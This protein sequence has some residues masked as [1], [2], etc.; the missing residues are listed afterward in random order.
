[1]V[2]ITLP[3]RRGPE[4]PVRGA[5]PP[6]SL[7][8]RSGE[9]QFAKDITTFFA[10]IEKATA[11]NEIAMGM[12]QM[13]GLTESLDTFIA[14][15]PNA[16]TDEIK[17]EWDRI[18]TQI[19]DIPKDFSRLGKKK[20]KDLTNLN[21]PLARHQA[22]TQAAATKSKQEL[23]RAEAQR[24]LDIAN[25]DIPAIIANGEAGIEAGTY[26]RETKELIIKQDLKVV[27]KAQEKLALEQAKTTILGVAQTFRFKDG[28]NKGEID[29][30]AGQ[31]FIKDSELPEDAKLETL[32]DLNTWNAQEQQA[33]DQQREV[34]R[35]VINNQLY[36][37]LDFDKAVATIDASA[38]DEKEQ[39][40]KM[41]E[42]RDLQ[43]LW[44]KGG[45]DAKQEKVKSDLLV[46]ISKD[47]RKYNEEFLSDEALAGNIH[48][49]HLPQLKLWRDKVVKGLTGTISAKKGYK[50][51]EV[52]S[53]RG[54]FGKGVDGAN[55]YIEATDNFTEFLLEEDRSAKEVTE[56]I[57]NMTPELGF[58][59]ELFRTRSF[60][61]KLR[62]RKIR[63]LIDIEAERL[64][65]ERLEEE[66]EELAIDA[67][68]EP[69]TK[70]EFIATS[71]S[72]TDQTNKQIYVDKWYRKF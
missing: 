21:M 62:A 52:Y 40:R 66:P 64:E 65:A 67:T 59:E 25:L 71:N 49:S 41:K 61:K 31:K 3:K 57:K 12:G 45:K 9:K 1:M 6:I 13:K 33:L 68:K 10:D 14:E 18:E 34:D 4:P 16:K 53:K 5:L 70:E 51:L 60:E 28:K 23:I 8:D 72:I 48:P 37:E 47:S 26:D 15:N 22:W 29:L 39:G 69:A 54:V 27:R 55:L 17:A 42:A 44:A 46:K 19:N 43:L 32:R 30:M 36:K 63:G 58:W 24:K 2:Q 20:F 38:L 56:Y 35:D 7:A 50:L 11:A